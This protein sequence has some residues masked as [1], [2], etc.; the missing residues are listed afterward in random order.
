MKRLAAFLGAGLVLAP[1]STLAKPGD[2]IESGRIIAVD[3]RPYRMVH[4]FALSTGVIPTDAFYVGL[5]LGGSYTLHL[6][7]VWAWEAV[8]F[9]YSAN[10]STD[11]ESE[12]QRR[13]QAAPEQDPELQYLVGSHVMFTPF[14]GKE[15]IFNSDI[16]FQGVHLALGGGLSNFAG[17]RED[18]FRPHISAGPGLRVFFGQVVSARLDLRGFMTLDDVAG[19]LETDFFFHGFLSVAFNFGKTRAT[20][21]GKNED[22]DPLTGFEKLDELYPRS[23]PEA[24]IVDEEEEKDE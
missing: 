14:F 7:D 12:L 6:S 2:R 20:E 19:S 21:I 22:V 10:V 5:S 9:H 3:E 4:E 24:I 16:V 18:S 13:F 1:A 15:T 8:S 11:L 17:D 23:N